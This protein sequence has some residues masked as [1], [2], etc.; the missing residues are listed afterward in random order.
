MVKFPGLPLREKARKSRFFLI[1]SVRLKN[2]S[3]CT[4]NPSPYV[5][6][7][8][9]DASTEI[10]NRSSHSSSSVI[11]MIIRIIIGISVIRRAIRIIMMSSFHTDFMTIPVKTMA[12]VMTSLS[13]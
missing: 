11:G 6:D 13:T 5:S 12:L 7:T 8:R 10:R 3:Q 1:R 2:R 9:P 4:P